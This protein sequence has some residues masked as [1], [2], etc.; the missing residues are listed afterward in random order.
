MD[1]VWSCLLVLKGIVKVGVSALRIVK[2]GV[3]A[4]RRF[5][6]GFKIVSR[7]LH[8]EAEGVTEGNRLIL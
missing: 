5:I 1:E 8:G 2:V 6:G 7:R 4:L 3:S